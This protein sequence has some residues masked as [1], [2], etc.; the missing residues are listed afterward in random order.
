MLDIMQRHNIEKLA[1]IMSYLAW[2]A[3]CLSLQ[4]D[5]EFDPGASAKVIC[6]PEPL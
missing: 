5:P 1:H 2:R 6:T 4:F 3:L